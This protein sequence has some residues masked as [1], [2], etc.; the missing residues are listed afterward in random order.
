MCGKERRTS[1]GVV[2]VDKR[3][4]KIGTKDSISQDP[5]KLAELRWAPYPP[6]EL[7][8]KQRGYLRSLAHHMKPVVLIGQEGATEIVI[9]E[10]RRQLLAHEL[11]KVKWTGLSKDEGN[12]KEQARE[13][14]DRVGAHYVYLMGQVLILYREIEPRYLRPGQSKRIQLPA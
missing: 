12:K 9:G 11:I 14:A 4:K 6:G 8:G 2:K 13:F 3:E 1:L 10:T 5:A 7:T